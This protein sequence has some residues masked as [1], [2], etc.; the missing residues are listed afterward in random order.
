M[1]II[2]GH[3]RNIYTKHVLI[4]ESWKKNTQGSSFALSGTHFSEDENICIL[5]LWFLTSLANNTHISYP[6]RCADYLNENINVSSTCMNIYA[7]DQGGIANFKPV[8]VFNDECAQKLSRP[9]KTHIAIE[10]ER[11]RDRETI[12]RP[13]TPCVYCVNLQFA[14]VI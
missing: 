13:Y 6:T 4:K 2:H 8:R 3:G 10:T 5:R 11:K 1:S 14:M 12:K 9:T 7:N